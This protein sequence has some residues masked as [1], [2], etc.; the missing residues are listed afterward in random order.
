MRLL[1]LKNGIWVILLVLA[2]RNPFAPMLVS[3]Y[4][5]SSGLITQQKTPEEVLQNFRFAYTFKDSLI[6]SD[7]L[8]STF[9]FR[10]W[11]YNVYPPQPLEWGRDTDLRITARMFRYFNRLDL[12]WNTI[13]PLDTFKLNPEYK[14]TFTLTIDGGQSIPTLNGEVLF[15]FILRGKKYYIALWEDQK[16]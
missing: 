16:L 4:S 11:D 12:T 15:R 8:D 1:R 9:I 5:P 13:L 2:C 7:V 6:Y 10:S 3:D 14:V